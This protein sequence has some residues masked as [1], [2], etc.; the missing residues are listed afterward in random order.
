MLFSIKAY[1]LLLQLQRGV[2]GR[3]AC[4]RMLLPPGSAPQLQARLQR[5]VFH[6]EKSQTPQITCI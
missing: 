3:D 2:K 5:P 6:T 4:G 1:I